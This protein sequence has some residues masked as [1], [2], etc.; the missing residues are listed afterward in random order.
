MYTNHAP[1]RQLDRQKKDRHKADLKTGCGEQHWAKPMMVKLTRGSSHT[2]HHSPPPSFS[3]QA[4]ACSLTRLVYFFSSF[5][6]NSYL[7]HKQFK[8]L[9]KTS[10]S[11]TPCGH[12]QVVMAVL[13]LAL[14]RAIC[15][16]NSISSDVFSSMCVYQNA[17]ILRILPY[18]CV[19][20][21]FLTRSHSLLGTHVEVIVTRTLRRER[22]H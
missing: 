14:C 10:N 12:R 18:S 21:A 3:R 8:I 22:F 16:L 20:L 17:P 9:T 5:L 6:V 4:R 13:L 19:S 7:S 15:E 11:D 2:P 1:Y